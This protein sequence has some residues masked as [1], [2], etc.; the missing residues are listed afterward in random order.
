MKIACISSWPPRQCGIASFCS[1]LC[2]GILQNGRHQV[3]IVAISREPE[4]YGYGPEV[5]F[6][7]IQ[8]DP[9]SYR[10][11]A[12]ILNETN[13]DAVI[14]QHEYGL[15][16]GPDG[17]M[18]LGLATDL[19]VPI[20]TVLHT[21]L[22]RPSA[23]Q[24]K[25]L[26]KLAQHSE[27]VV[28]IAERARSI[29]GQ[30]YAIT[31][32]RVVHLPHGVPNPPD[33]QAVKAVRWQLGGTN[34]PI[35][36]SFGLLGPGKGLELAIRSVGEAKARGA[37]FTYY[38]VGATH[39][40]ER[41][42]H[43]EAY[44]NGLQRMINMMGL[45]ETI[46]LIDKFLDEDELMA[47]IAA[48][49][50]YLT[51]Y[52][53]REQ[54]SSGT[55]SFALGLGKPIISTPFIYAEE[56]L[57]DGSGLLVPFNDHSV[58]GQAIHRLVGDLPYRRSVAQRASV[59]GRKMQWD[60]VAQ[61]YIKLAKTVARVQPICKAK[62][63]VPS[64][65]NIA[66]IDLIKFPSISL[67]H[68]LRLTDDTGLLQHACG[69]IPNRQLGYTTDDN[70]RA[71]LAMALAPKEL[72]PQGVKL[73]ENYLAFLQYAKEQEG[74]FHNAF[75]YDRRPLPESRSD[76]CQGRTLWALAAAARIWTELPLAKV[77]FR[78]FKES[79]HTWS[80]MR[81]IRGLSL[82]IMAVATCLRSTPSLGTSN[83]EEPTPQLAQELTK[84]LEEAADFLASEY[85]QTAGPGWQW[86]ENI[87]SYSCGLMPAALFQAYGVLPKKEYLRIATESLHF[88]ADKTITGGIFRPIGNRG[89]Y[90]REGKQAEYDQQPIEAWAMTLAAVAAYD[91]T[92]NRHWVSLADSAERWYL[93][94]NDLGLSLY[95]SRT[96]GCG[97]GLH[98]EGISENQGA[99][100]TLAYILTRSLQEGVRER[101]ITEVQEA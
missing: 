83:C 1:D 39:P 53:N 94:Q 40:N 62:A 10:Q 66:K 12:K 88:L 48:C 70:A 26:C 18:I 76:D 33:P 6:E 16:G 101:I 56:M 52:P 45:G 31:P 34:K 92:R 54:I 22:S 51:P 9:D 44:R 15:Y 32:N 96:S 63:T 72:K 36:M 85:R 14:I 80:Q 77:A 30:T 65:E 90:P 35:L 49:D 38:V 79:V 97:D 57:G 19:K 24:Y 23:G 20:I 61:D 60:L 58:M 7:L 81:S 29:L 42:Q 59:K 69:S 93:G 71:L 89:W 67:D 75:S 37:D 2:R 64:T 73:A 21:V 86:Y 13:P 41:R 78:M 82:A 11:A 50:I 99:E 87:L 91:V 84:I 3:E 55:L 28:I 98:P 17:D 46:S 47:H 68:L 74:W 43:G 27:K 8:D 4:E 100:S 95:D 5:I 25:V